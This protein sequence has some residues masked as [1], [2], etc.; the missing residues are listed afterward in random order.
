MTDPI[1]V[2]RQIGDITVTS[3]TVSTPAG[4]TP[5]VGSQWTA[6]D[7]WVT[8]RRTPQW[9][10]IVAIA[11]ICFTALLSLLLLLV[12]E[13]IYRCSVSVSVMGDK[14]FYTTRMEFTTPAA[15]QEVYDNVN[16][17]RALALAP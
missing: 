6:V 17:V 9:A 7:Q 10:K 1:Q 2:I 15:V 12:K 8:E 5:L 3:T 4:A 14:F 13:E 16:Y 11:G